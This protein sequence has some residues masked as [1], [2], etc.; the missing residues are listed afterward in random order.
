MKNYVAVA[1]ALAEL[2]TRGL[3]RE[4][5]I[6]NLCALPSP[7][8]YPLMTRGTSNTW[9]VGLTNF[10]L[11]QTREIVDAGVTVAA[12]QVQLSL[13]DRRPEASGLS[14]YCMQHGICILPYGVLAGGLLSDRYLGK[15]PP[16]TDPAEHE[17][18]SLTK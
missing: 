14:A 18:R 5:G 2:R 11:A 9:Q 3:V 10:G 4:V 13:L 7:P 6:T 15:P 8:C 17:T 12:T 1:L 16:S